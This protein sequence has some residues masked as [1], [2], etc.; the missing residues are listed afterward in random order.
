MYR[1]LGIDYGEKRIGIAM[2]DPLQII[3]SPFDVFENNDHVLDKIANLVEE[4][5]V[6]IVVVGNP[7]NLKGEQTLSTQNAVR[8]KETLDTKISVPVVLWDERL[9]TKSANNSL[10]EG[11]VSRAK[12]KQMVDKIAAVF[13]LQSYMDFTK[14]R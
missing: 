7:L 13:I 8:F 3:A 14:K 10:I 5:N 1:M 11:N 6:S 4:Y 12:R 2:T 9:S